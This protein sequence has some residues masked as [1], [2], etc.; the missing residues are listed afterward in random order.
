LPTMLYASSEKHSSTFGPT[1]C[2]AREPP[3]P[4]PRR[5]RGGASLDHAEDVIKDLN[6]FI[7]SSNVKILSLT[8]VESWIDPAALTS[9]HAKPHTPST[10]PDIS[11][12][13]S[14][15]SKLV[16]APS[17]VPRHLPDRRHT[18]TNS[19]PFKFLG[20]ADEVVTWRACGWRNDVHS[21]S[22]RRAAAD[23]G[24]ADAAGTIIHMFAL[25]RGWAWRVIPWGQF[26]FFFPILCYTSR[27]LIAC[28]PRPCPCCSGA[29]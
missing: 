20:I 2:L 25:G 27:Q 24:G 1:A 29:N 18:G 3:V 19:T 28:F 10:P 7:I 14:A 6:R 17:L 11:T 8:V 23:A 4:A 5:G 13:A 26:F 21:F 15:R 9:Q 12:R 16:A 22:Y